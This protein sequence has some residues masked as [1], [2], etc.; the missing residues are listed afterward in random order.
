[1]LKCFVAS[2][3]GR[4]D[5]DAV[6]DRC[7]HPALKRLSIQPLR[8][9][10]VEHNDDIDDKILEFLDACDLAIVD[11]TYARPS[12]Y[13]EAGVAFGSDKPVVYIARW[14]H[15]KARD[16]DPEGL[17]RVHFDLQ[18]KNIIKWSAPNAAF[19]ARLERRLRHVTGPLMRL[20]QQAHVLDAE[21][22]A[23]AALSQHD[24]LE[25]LGEKSQA[26]LMSRGYKL[27]KAEGYY[28]PWPTRFTL[29]RESEVLR[30]EV[31][32][33]CNPTAT[34]RDLERYA[35]WSSLGLRSTGVSVDSRFH[36]I[37]VTLR[38]VPSARR[39]DALPGFT[40]TVDGS[41][42][43]KSFGGMG[44]QYAEDTV[45]HFIDGVR[46]RSELTERMR[47]L[48]VDHELEQHA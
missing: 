35:K 18:M 43:R 16:S 41:M 14:D 37:L 2:A 11:L 26:L 3:F 30:V 23:F 12:A 48:I 22:R 7:V 5:V 24:Q 28:M 10:R 20:E 25:T 36:L 38:S 21:R 1:M 15:L 19:A 44:H 4:D 33:D 34:K 32:V 45:I 17:L 47:A 39:Q 40:T 6:Y 29:Y 27:R 8:V 46:S 9:D 13:F 31:G 42:S